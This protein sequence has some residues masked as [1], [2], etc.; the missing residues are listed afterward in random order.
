M[1]RER[2]K[3]LAHL[4]ANLTTKVQVVV[5]GCL[6]QFAY[7]VLPEPKHASGLRISVR[8]A[9]NQ[10]HGAPEVLFHVL[11]EKSCDPL[12][13]WIVACCRL[14]ARWLKEHKCIR[15]PLYDH[16]RPSLLELPPSDGQNER[17]GCKCSKP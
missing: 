6:S 7:A 14:L 9:L 10:A 11:T 5:T 4:P 17:G 13:T 12:C 8:H 2:L 16:S 3:R 15:L 1:C